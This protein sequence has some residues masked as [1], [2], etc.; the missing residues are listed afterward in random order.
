MSAISQLEVIRAEAMERLMQNADYR[1]VNKLDELIGDLRIL[2]PA[3]GSY[4]G[5]TLTETSAT[6]ETTIDQ[7]TDVYVA[8]DLDEQFETLSKD[9]SESVRDQTELN[10]SASH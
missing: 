9:L 7:L 2:D 1:L 5:S 10:G 6:P 3:I 4:T 8:K